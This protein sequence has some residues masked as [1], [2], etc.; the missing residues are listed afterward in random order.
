ME[1]KKKRK[2]RGGQKERN[3]FLDKTDLPK[4]SAARTVYETFWNRI[5][6][7]LMGYLI[8]KVTMNLFYQH[9]TKMV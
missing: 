9:K 6:D 3:V 1:K 2:K 8:F 4:R 5:T 7:Y